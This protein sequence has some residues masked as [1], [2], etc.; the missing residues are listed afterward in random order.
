MHHALGVRVGQ[1]PRNLAKHPRRV[2]WRERSLSIDPLTESDSFYVRH[3][4]E[5]IL[6]YFLDGKNCND[7]WM[8]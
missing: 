1:R 2:C 6:F 4:D 5:H 8:R 3:N 7:V